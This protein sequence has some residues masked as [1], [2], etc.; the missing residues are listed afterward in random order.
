MLKRQFSAGDTWYTLVL[1]FDMT[2]AQMTEAFGAGYRLHVL[3]DSYFKTETMLYLKFNA[4]TALP[5]GTPCLFRPGV[6]ITENVIIHDVTIDD[7]TADILTTEINML[8]I[9]DQ[10][11]VPASELNYYLGSNNY[12]YRYRETKTTKGFR[13][14]FHLNNALPQNCSARVVFQDET[15]TDMEDVEMPEADSVRKIIRNGQVVIIRGGV[16]YN[17]QGMRIK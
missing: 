11:D 10:T 14:Y 15:P 7:A 2:A 1:P 6:D 5:A 8:G 9:Y 3:Q 12:L 17:A 13:A 4:V 16:E